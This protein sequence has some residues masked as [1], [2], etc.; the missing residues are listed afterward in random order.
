MLILEDYRKIG[1]LEQSLAALN[2]S[3]DAIAGQSSSLNVEFLQQEC[4]GI[5][6]GVVR[7]KVNLKRD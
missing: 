7:V 5:A 1:D 2:K 6:E 3:T 4:K